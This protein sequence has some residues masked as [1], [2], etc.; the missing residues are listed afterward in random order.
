[1]RPFDE[2]RFAEHFDAALPTLRRSVQRFGIAPEDVEEMLAVARERMIRAHLDHD[3]RRAFIRSVEGVVRRLE[4]DRRRR[5]DAR[6]RRVKRRRHAEQ[7]VSVPED[8]ID[9]HASDSLEQ[10]ELAAAV[11][12][13]LAASAA[14]VHPRVIRAVK[15][16]GRGGRETGRRYTNSERWLISAARRDATWATLVDRLQELL[17][18]GGLL[19]ARLRSRLHSSPQQ[20]AAALAVAAATAGTI[21]LIAAHSAGAGTRTQ[22]LRTTWPSKLMNGGATRDARASTVGLHSDPYILVTQRPVPSLDGGR[23][24][25]GA[26]VSARLPTKGSSGDITLTISRDTEVTRGHTWL[27]T[28][29]YCDNSRVA[30][31]VCAAAEPVLPVL[32]TATSPSH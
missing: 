15:L 13:T 10:V 6:R 29:V 11:R 24:P 28:T 14:D 5:I 30:R 22:N 32:A 21:G 26:S 20:I 23:R 17:A 12:Q 8:A 19:W 3:N 9:W 1:M 2:Q 7:V 18:A 16:L 4:L 31:A 27:S 25:I